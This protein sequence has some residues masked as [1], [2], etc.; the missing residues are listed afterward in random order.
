MF[1]YIILCV[2]DN[3]SETIILVKI[4]LEVYTRLMMMMAIMVIIIIIII[5]FFIYS[6]NKALYQGGAS[7][8]NNNRLYIVYYNNVYMDFALNGWRL[9]AYHDDMT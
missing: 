6:N 1:I 3:C 9:N 8:Y 4:D 2:Y 7:M 5:I